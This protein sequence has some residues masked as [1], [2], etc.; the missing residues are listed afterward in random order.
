[1]VFEAPA[2]PRTTSRRATPRRLAVPRL[3]AHVEAPEWPPVRGPRRRHCALAPVT[4]EWRLRPVPRGHDRLALA[5][6]AFRH[7]SSALP[8]VATTSRPS[9]SYRRPCSYRTTAS[10]RPRAYKTPSPFSSPARANRHRRWAHL[11]ACP[12]DR[13]VTLSSSLA[14]T[15]ASN[16]AWWPSIAD[17]SPQP[18]P[19]RPCCHCLIAGHR[20]MPLRPSHHRGSA[21]RESNRP[22]PSLVCLLRPDLAAGELVPPREGTVV[23]GICPRWLVC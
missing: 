14:H 8:H 11:L 7:W 1:M 3:C 23:K 16:R 20:R 19:R 18:E 15:W 22:F 12:R 10:A 6:A 5:R 9:P 4:H 21:T 2:L 13:P 17:I